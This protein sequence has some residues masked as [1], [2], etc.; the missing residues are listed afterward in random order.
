MTPSPPFRHTWTASWVIY[1]SRGRRSSLPWEFEGLKRSLCAPPA[2]PA[3]IRSGGASVRFPRQRPRE[4]PP[5]ALPQRLRRA[6]APPR[7]HQSGCGRAGSCA[8]ASAFSSCAFSPRSASVRAWAWLR[9]PPQQP[10]QSRLRKPHP[11]PPWE[12]LR[13]GRAPGRGPGG[14]RAAWTHAL[15]ASLRPA[16][17]LLRDIL[18]FPSLRRCAVCL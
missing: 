13:G 5:L 1:A 15:P 3:W 8:A 12:C 9:L 10:R 17:L 14:E 2:P 16:L 4:L 11:G 6:P 7:R 18:P